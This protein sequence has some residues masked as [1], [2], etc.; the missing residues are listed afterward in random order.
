[1]K[2]LINKTLYILP[3]VFLY[4]CEPDFDDI[5]FNGG[6]ADLSKFVTV[7]NSLTAGVQSNALSAAGQENSLSNILATQFKQ[8]GGS[9]FK[10]PIIPGQ[11]GI[12]GVGVINSLYALGFVLPELKLTYVTDCKGVSSLA[13]S[14]V[15]Q[16]NDTL[17]LPIGP[18][19]A[20]VPVPLPKARY[21]NTEFAA[22]VSASGPYNNIGISGAKLIDA[23]DQTF[24]NPYLGRMVSMPGE[25]ML[26]LAK[27][28][29]ATFFMMWLGANDVLSYA[30]GGGD[31]AV[32][33]NPRAVLTSVNDFSADYK[34]ALDELTS[35]GAKG[36]VANIPNVTSIPYFTTVEW[37]ALELTATQAAQLN[38]GFSGYNDSMDVIVQLNPA[39]TQEEAD[40]RKIRFKEGKNALVIFDAS[41]TDLTSIDARL[42]SMRQIKSTE[43]LTLTTPSD[44]IK[45]EGFGSVD[46]RDPNP[47]N[48]K[49]NPITENFVLDEDEIATINSRTA[50]FNSII[51]SEASSRGLALFDANTRMKELA[52]TGITISG[53]EFT[54]TLVTGGAFSLDGVHPS[55]RGYAI[56]AN[57][58][59]EAINSKYGARVPKVDVASYPVI[60]VTN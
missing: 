60:E 31:E 52:T 49:P 20:L 34:N 15:P 45:C 23:D 30:T 18:G 53:I 56:L 4:G 39:F 22:N 44:R 47:L 43:L 46:T 35:N 7:G 9:E 33:T 21:S 48:W 12:K 10:Q 16:G 41:L 51:Q 13:P 26:D 42:L 24:A 37:D 8:V 2:R 1:M 11:S 5:E 27:K 32:A 57:D 28:V 17:Q 14:F 59:I 25:T 6:S 29:N 50:S 40:R 54:S 36:V 3:L 58:I 19:G 38:A 55:T